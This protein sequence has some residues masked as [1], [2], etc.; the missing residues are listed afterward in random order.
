MGSKREERPAARRRRRAAR[1]AALGVTSVVVLAGCGSSPPKDFVGFVPF[2]PS[3]SSFG[4]IPPTT[5]PG[6][7]VA[8]GA[9]TTP[10]AAAASTA[11]TAWQSVTGSLTGM[12]SE[13]GN[14]TLVSARPDR[15]V[16]ITGV[17]QHGL[18][19]ND[20][21]SATWKPLGTG[22]GSAS[23]INRASTIVY[24]PDHPDTFWESGIYNAGGVYRTDDGGATFR[25]LGDVVH[26]DAVSVDFT[27]PARKTLLSG[28][29]E[30]STLLRSKDGGQSWTDISTTLPA[31]VGFAVGPH[32]VDAQTYVLG[33][34]FGEHSG[35][36]R[37][38]DGGATWTPVF[39]GGVAGT[40][41]A[42]KS[43]GALYWVLQSGGIIKS[44]DGGATWTTAARSATAA[45]I[46]TN[47]TEL[48]DGRLAAVGNQ[49]VI[50]SSDHGATWRAAGP[51]MPYVP[52]GFTY[53]A[54]R[55]AFYIWYFTC[56]FST[57][58]PIPDNAIM[59]LSFA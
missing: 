4:V 22:S 31:G 3:T 52:T 9:T 10:T 59:S 21:S 8:G 15:D 41:L 43:D 47:L 23:I 6:T 40:V 48:P 58:N 29:H 27:D 57:Q 11:G 36:F 28:T 38:T 2:T 17:A 26:S 35:I 13:C 50:V 18:F 16:I 1:C 51:K 44:T 24:D 33:T 42:A 37:T 45:A 7:T 25:Q 12:P 49:V 32:V 5:T 55:K 54:Q 34:A 53:S 14:L 56:D 39:T 30:R 19:A 46:Q 20:D